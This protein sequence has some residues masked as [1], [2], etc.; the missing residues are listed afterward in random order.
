MN[1][2]SRREFLKDAALTGVAISAGTL[3]ERS[4]FATAAPA[5]GPASAGRSAARSV[6]LSLLS[7]EPSSVPAGISWGVPWPQG[8]VGRNSAFSLSAQGSGLP[9][10]S[11]PLAY[12]PDGSI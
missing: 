11:W 10:Q 12:W 6:E 9:L 1:P 7:K 3:T 4:L 5:Q 2:T 8:S